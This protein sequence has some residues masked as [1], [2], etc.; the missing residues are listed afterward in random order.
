MEIEINENPRQVERSFSL[1]IT[2]EDAHIIGEAILTDKAYPRL[3]RRRTE[4]RYELGR[5]CALARSR[6]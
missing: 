5:I 4:R 2:D 3:R 1:T 6:S